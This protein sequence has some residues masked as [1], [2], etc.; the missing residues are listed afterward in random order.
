MHKPQ[1]ALYT[2]MQSFD[3]VARLGGLL[4][5]ASFVGAHLRPGGGV[6]VG[7]MAGGPGH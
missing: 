7:V 2:P 6:V 4:L 3:E 1:A 5:Q